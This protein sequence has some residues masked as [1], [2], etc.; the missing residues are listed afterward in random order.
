MDA[1]E[2]RSW[3]S[4]LGREISTDFHLCMSMVYMTVKNDAYRH[5]RSSNR[6]SSKQHTQKSLTA[7][8]EH[9]TDRQATHVEARNE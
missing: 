5:H 2:M 1:V 4:C 9:D 8:R 3:T 6:N 7:A